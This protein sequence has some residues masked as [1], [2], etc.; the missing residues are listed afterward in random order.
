MSLFSL[1]AIPDPIENR[2]FTFCIGGQV[3]VYLPFNVFSFAQRKSVWQ[4]A[5]EINDKKYLVAIELVEDPPAGLPGKDTLSICWPLVMTLLK[6]LL[7]KMHRIN[8]RF[9]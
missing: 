5:E 7:L 6:I 1:S 3:I 8:F 9:A 2:D 4:A